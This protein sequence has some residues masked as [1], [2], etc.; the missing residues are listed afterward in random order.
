[1]FGIGPTEVIIIL[2]FLILPLLITLLLR[3]KYP[4]KIWVGLILCFLFTPIGQFYTKGAIVYVIALFVFHSI[5]A[6]VL[7]NALAPWPLTII[8]SMTIIY[9]RLKKKWVKKIGF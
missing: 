6:A 8:L 4:E 7:G 2:I 5:F 9:F 1:M 3:M